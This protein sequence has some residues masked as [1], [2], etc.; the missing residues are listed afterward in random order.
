MK[1][2]II[3]VKGFFFKV[4]GWSSVLCLMLAWTWRTD[5][6]SQLKKVVIKWSLPRCFSYRCSRTMEERNGVN[7]SQFQRTPGYRGLTQSRS[8]KCW[9]TKHQ[10]VLIG[11]K[12]HTNRR[13][14]ITWPDNLFSYK[15]IATTQT[16]LASSTHGQ[17]GLCHLFLTQ[18]Q[19]CL[20]FIG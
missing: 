3:C 16:R 12:K 14:E 13:K 8:S 10:N 1:R 19:A 15:G 9:H 4:L 18:G 11:T 20:L 2:L 6:S 5:I 7:G 17:G